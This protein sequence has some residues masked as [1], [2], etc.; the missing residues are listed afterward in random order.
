MIHLV[1]KVLRAI[2]IFIC[3]RL[4]VDQKALITRS[5]KISSHPLVIVR[6]VKISK[7]C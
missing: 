7:I 3:G 5:A 6:F 4:D 1:G 2:I